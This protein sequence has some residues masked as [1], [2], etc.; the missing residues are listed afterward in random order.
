MALYPVLC[1]CVD[2]DDFADHGQPKCNGAADGPRAWLEQATLL[3]IFTYAGWVSVL[4]SIFIGWLLD[5][6][7]SRFVFVVSFLA[8]GLAYIW[9][10]NCGTIWE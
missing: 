4:G 5:R 10:G 9:W 6:K 2:S 7:G 3:S 8:G 1:D